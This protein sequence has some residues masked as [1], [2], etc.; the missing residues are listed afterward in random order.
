MEGDP[1]KGSGKDQG[2]LGSQGVREHTHCKVMNIGR[3]KRC[4]LNVTST[5]EE[6][7]ES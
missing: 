7:S 6:R 1:P 5:E 3:L 2:E 4:R